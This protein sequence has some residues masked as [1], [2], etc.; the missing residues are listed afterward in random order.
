M[1]RWQRW[2]R[3]VIRLARRIESIE[4]LTS[5]GSLFGKDQRA[6]F[7]AW[8]RLADLVSNSFFKKLDLP[9]EGCEPKYS[10]DLILYG[11]P[12]GMRSGI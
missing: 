11:G 12:T 6:G 5:L 7:I 1:I 3:S 4:K 10:I 8:R 9:I 2:D